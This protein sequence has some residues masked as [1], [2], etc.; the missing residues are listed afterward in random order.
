[1]KN[2]ALVICLFLISGML[3]SQTSEKKPARWK[4]TSFNMSLG[5]ASFF[6]SGTQSDYDNLKQSVEDPDLFVDPS[7]FDNQYYSDWSGDFTPR[8]S[9]GITPYSKKKGEYNVNR[10]IRFGIGSNKGSR[11]YF[12]FYNE[13]KIRVDTFQSVNGNPNIYADSNYVNNFYYSEDFIDLSFSFSYLFKTNANKRFHAYAGVGV[14][15]AITLKYYVTANQFENY[16]M[17]Y[18]Q[19]GTQE[20]SSP[21]NSYY[22]SYYGYLSSS[23]NETKMKS[24]A[25]FIRAFIPVG[26]NFRFSNNNS[27]FKHLNIYSE[28]NPGIEFQI[29]PGEQNYVN[30]YFGVAWVGLSYKW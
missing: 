11:R 2:L 1:M 3:Q 30:P 22:Q 6:V 25:H 9:I 23:Y 21:Y 28:I 15:Y 5:S 12:S 4:V 7:N 17:T 18:S 20:G 26:I 29:I 10:E 14:E 13:E 8:I 27:F 16:I 24:P 19:E